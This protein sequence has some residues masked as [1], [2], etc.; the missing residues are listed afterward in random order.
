MRAKTSDRNFSGGLCQVFN[1]FSPFFSFISCHV[2]KEFVNLDLPS[3]DNQ[4]AEFCNKLNNFCELLD[5][6]YD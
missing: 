5:L 1:D 2:G 3:V 4:I 6:I